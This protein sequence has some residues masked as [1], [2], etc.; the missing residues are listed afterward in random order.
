MKNYKSSEVLF[1][2]LKRYEASVKNGLY[3]AIL[4][5]HLGTAPERTDKF[6]NKL[7]E[8][9]QYFSSKGYTFKKL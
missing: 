5:I 3:G 4:L 2:D 1:N 8:I 7:E 9:I 6:Y